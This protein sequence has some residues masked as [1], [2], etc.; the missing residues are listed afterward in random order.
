MKISKKIHYCWFGGGEKSAD[1][2]KYKKTWEEFFPDFEI[3]EW[4][5]SNF[6]VYQNPYCEEAYKKK[7]WAFVSDYAR[8]KILYDHG[9]IYLDT[10]MEII[11]KFPESF[12]ETDF[13]GFEQ[14]NYVAAGI[15]GAQKNSSHIAEF[16][17][18]YDNLSFDLTTIVVRISNILG[19][20][21][22]NKNIF[23]T[24][25]IPDNL[26]IYPKDFFYPSDEFGKIYPTKN[27]YAIHH[28]AGSWAPLH[29]KI[30]YKIVI[31]SKKFLSF[32]Q[33]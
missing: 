3:I 22:K 19:D 15:I 31:I 21:V 17:K 33:K 12:F 8:L 28:Y 4:N 11:K 25:F 9:G 24:I 27:S 26:T 7:K 29:S 5:E 10:D 1:F 2:Y 30:L 16:L 32:F 6:D 13:M 14:K 18:I 23:E 20:A